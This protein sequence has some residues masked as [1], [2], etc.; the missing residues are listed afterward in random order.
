M[1]DGF[2]GEALAD[3]FGVFM[4]AEV[5]DSVLVA[6]PRRGRAKGPSSSFFTVAKSLAKLAPA[7]IV[8]LR[9]R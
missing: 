2:A 1:T 5:G 8:A 6:T 4:D 9:G 7:S 3:D